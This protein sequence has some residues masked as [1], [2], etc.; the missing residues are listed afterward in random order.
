MLLLA[1]LADRFRELDI[2][3]PTSKGGRRYRSGCGQAFCKG[4]VQACASGSQERV[5]RL[6]SGRNS[7]S[8]GTSISFSG[9]CMCV[10]M[11]SQLTQSGQVSLKYASAF[12]YHSMRCSCGGAKQEQASASTCAPQG[13]ACS[14]CFQTDRQGASW[15]LCLSCAAG[16]SLQC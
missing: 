3:S 10:P 1:T 2:S 6:C 15:L 13:F 4:R 7:A 16:K 12:R 9:R 14:P 11:L 8:R 5:S